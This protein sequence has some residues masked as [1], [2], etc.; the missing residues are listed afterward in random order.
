MLLLFW[1]FSALLAPKPTITERPDFKLFFDRQELA[2]S[3]LLYD[4]KKDRFTAYRYDRCQQ[5]F[6]PASTYKIINTL[7]GLET[8]VIPDENYVIKWDDVKRDISAWNQDHTL[9]SAFRVSAVP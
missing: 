4:Q 6:L 8:G 5:G 2:G 9:Q 1:L 7:I 3:F